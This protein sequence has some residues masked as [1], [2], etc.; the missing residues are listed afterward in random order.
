MDADEVTLVAGRGI[1]QEVEAVEHE[2]SCPSPQWIT[3]RIVEK[4]DFNYDIEKDEAVCHNCGAISQ[5]LDSDDSRNLVLDKRGGEK[6]SDYVE[7]KRPA[8]F[9]APDV[10]TVD[11]DM[12]T[13]MRLSLI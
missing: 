3:G 11:N 2:E 12:T 10:D 1:A 5:V 8:E 13:A 6:L 7:D 4:T 9:I